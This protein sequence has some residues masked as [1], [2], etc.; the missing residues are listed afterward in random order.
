MDISAVR[1]K[2]EERSR[3]AEGTVPDSPSRPSVDR[4][5][6]DAPTPSPVRPSVET[7]GRSRSID[8]FAFPPASPA[9]SETLPS[10]YSPSPPSKR[11]T[12]PAPIIASPLSPNTTGVSVVVPDSPTNGF[13][14][15]EP[16]RIHLPVSTPLGSSSIAAVR[17]LSS[18]TQAA[19]ASSYTPSSVRLRRSNTLESLNPNSTGSSVSSE[20]SVRS[21]TT[22]QT[23]VPNSPESS[24]TALRRR[25]TSLY[26]DRDVALSSPERTTR[27]PLSS[28]GMARTRSTSPEKPPA[29]TSVPP[30]PASASPSNPMFPTQYR[31]S[32][33]MKKRGMDHLGTGA[34]VRRLERIA[35]GDAP[36][37]WPSTAATA[38]DPPPPS[39]ERDRFSRR[40][41]RLHRTRDWRQP[42]PER[43]PQPEPKV[44]VRLDPKQELVIPGVTNA[45]DVAGVPRRKR[46]L[47]D[48]I[49]SNTPLPSTRL[50]RGL[51]ADVQRHLIQ[52]YEYLCHV[53]E[54]KEWIEGCLG[55]EL[56]FGVVEMEEQLRNGVVLAKLVRVFM[57]EGAVR[58]I[59]EVC[60]FE[61]CVNDD[62]NIKSGAEVGLQAF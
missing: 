32:Y 1:G 53:G 34:S 62:A 60:P 22:N 40:E 27:R 9:R 10:D 37:D 13:S 18:Y 44:E 12:M 43:L 50:T 41:D 2:W 17:N 14:N 8:R 55:E 36:E 30:S 6:S 59:Y 58:K 24:T 39:P 7:P 61:V 33:L 4:T 20:N 49:P 21:V 45:D 26:G 11:Y 51:W 38:D 23:T 31:S 54:A 25:P 42:S 29:S 28:L 5:R 48:T 35:S 56:P 47:R 57:G 16:Q 3:A 46:L 15:P 19:D 52:A